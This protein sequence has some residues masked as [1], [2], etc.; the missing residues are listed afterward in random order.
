M[1]ISLCNPQCWWP[2]LLVFYCLHDVKSDDASSSMKTFSS[3]AIVSFES[4][5]DEM[6]RLVRLNH[7]AYA[8]INGYTNVNTDIFAIEKARASKM[9]P[10]W[11]KIPLIRRALKNHEWVL[12]IDSDAIFVNSTSI[13]LVISI[14]QQLQG[15]SETSNRQASI[16]FSGDTNAIN[17]GILH[18][19]K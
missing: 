5:T 16:Y 18:L 14:A 1:R 7:A 9:Q 13:K 11:V 15:N 17:S 2:L 8:N 19:K 3:T 4:R 6:A 10:N 12:W